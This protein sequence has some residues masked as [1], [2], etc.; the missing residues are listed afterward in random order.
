MLLLFLL[1]LGGLKD[2]LNS[3]VENCFHILRYNTA[4]HNE[5]IVT[6][7]S[8]EELL[9]PSLNDRRIAEKMLQY[10]MLEL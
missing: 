9:P 3:C 6:K 7:M 4:S 1:L 5:K 10:I 8:L 2:H